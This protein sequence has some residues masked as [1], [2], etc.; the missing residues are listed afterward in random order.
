MEVEEAGSLATGFHVWE[1]GSRGRKGPWLTD[2]HSCCPLSLQRPLDA[3]QPTSPGQ[4]CC[5]GFLS[6][7]V[8]AV[9]PA[10]TAQEMW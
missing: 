1:G 10:G 8:C 9:C 6:A 7:G 4:Q 5:L 2:N 3:F